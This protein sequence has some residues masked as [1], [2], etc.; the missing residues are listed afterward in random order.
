MR[1]AALLLLASLLPAPA[2]AGSDV[3]R[4]GGPIRVSILSRHLKSMAAGELDRILFELPD[5]VSCVRA[6]G[7]TRVPVKTIEIAHRDGAFR[8]LLDGEAAGDRV[9]LTIEGAPGLTVGVRFRDDSRRYPLPLRIDASPRE[10]SIVASEEPER[11]ARDSAAAEYG[12][13]PRSG[14]EALEALS[15][16]V[17]ARAERA[18]ARPVHGN[19]HVCDLSH[20]QVY[21]GRLDRADTSIGEANFPWRID[22]TALFCEPVFHARCGGAT[23]GDG[24]F[25]LGE[26]RAPGVRDRLLGEGVYLCRNG[27]EGWTAALPAGELRSILGGDTGEIAAIVYDRAAC[28]LEIRT[29]RGPLEFAPEDFRLRINRVKGWSFLKSNNYE[30][31]KGDDAGGAAYLFSG[32]GLGHNA[33]LCQHG[34]LALAMRGFSRYEI[35]CHYFPGIGFV[36]GAHE[37]E[38]DSPY[39]SYV[40]FSLV[41]G[42]VLDARYAQI[43]SRSVAPGSVFKLLVSL[44]LVARR[45]DLA[46]GY[47]YT[48]E[49]ASADT[50]MPEKCWKPGGHGD[51]D[52]SRAISC[53]CNLYFA[54]LYAH[55][56]RADF[57]S[58]IASLSRRP[59]IAL[60]LP[61]IDGDAGF[62]R[63]LCGLDYRVKLT[64]R[65]LVKVA[66]TVS[67]VA[68]SDR[69]VDEFRRSL[70]AGG[71]EVI[72]AALAETVRTG[73]ASG[74]SE[75]YGSARENIEPL[76]RG[77][78]EGDDE[79]G[80][81][82]PSSSCWGK[83][84]TVMAGTNRY[85]SYGLFLGGDR[86]RGLITIVARGNGH[87]AAR[88]G[89][90]ILGR[91]P[92]A[93]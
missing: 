11:Y 8:V 76:R 88:W 54:S 44:Y 63:L 82:V 7:G 39:L 37:R 28:R 78:L 46:R 56:D 20:C 53:S 62:A 13:Q 57:A 92:P 2:W 80:G 60:A 51:T 59:G 4:N 29:D 25:S 34:A 32:R 91:E 41:T 83:T 35:L 89:L 30:V 69:P 22:A 50:H 1:A 72:R 18:R 87:L 15:L 49:G 81:M 52:L 65:D 74:E 61:D 23:L 70:P 77:P 85:L 33:G 31:R 86:D 6:D 17:L 21:R 75:P 43:L 36:R 66:M 5:N 16:L 45:P 73:T 14:A 84:S 10:I 12:P 48:C 64:V 24:V 19:A 55:I 58:F 93:R 38:P 68:V 79:P 3:A 90:R 47:R 71:L 67:P 26:K 9:S 27:R 42:E 40:G